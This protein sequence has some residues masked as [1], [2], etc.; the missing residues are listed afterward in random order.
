MSAYTGEDLRSTLANTLIFP[1][2]DYCSAVYGDLTGRLD[3]KLQ[4]AMN[5]CIRYVFS[6]GWRDHVTPYRIRLHWLT[7]RNRRLFLSS[8]LLHK[9]ILTSS[10]GH[11]IDLFQFQV[12]RYAPRR[13][14]PLL[15]IRSS[16]SQQLMDSF[17]YHTSN[18]WNSLPPLLRTSVSVSAF[19]SQLKP[20]LLRFEIQQANYIPT[21]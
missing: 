7:T 21:P 11:L 8:R 6:L 4:V 15:K 1:L 19:K 16:A 13:E 3:T 2:F 9:I 14:G 5:S 12:P 17:S 10:P 18:F 20:F